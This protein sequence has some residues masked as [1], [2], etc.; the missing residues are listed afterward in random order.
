M[1]CRIQIELGF[2]KVELDS[3]ACTQKKLPDGEVHEWSLQSSR[4]RPEMLFCVQLNPEA[5]SN[6]HSRL[7]IDC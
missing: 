3:S 2:P 4:T 6:K 7:R 1:E 5:F